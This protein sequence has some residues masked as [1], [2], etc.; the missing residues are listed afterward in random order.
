MRHKTVSTLLFYDSLIKFLLAVVW[1]K[2]VTFLS[3][4]SASFWGTAERRG[5]WLCRGFPPTWQQH[6]DSDS[7]GITWR[8]KIYLQ[9][10]QHCTT[11]PVWSESGSLQQHGRRPIQPR[12]QSFLCRRRWEIK[13]IMLIEENLSFYS[14]LL[15]IANMHN[16]WS[17]IFRAIW[18][19]IKSMGP[20]CVS[21]WDRGVLGTNSPWV[22]QRE[23][24]CI[25]GMKS[26]NNCA[27]RNIQTRRRH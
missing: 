12:R 17:I 19:A 7:V 3:P 25:W 18:G 22:Q 4:L 13:L 27:T 8:I 15:Y 5:L 24:H 6:L 23:D 20:H 2:G 16:S 26:W 9:K 11:V 1:V 21:L 14:T 10:R